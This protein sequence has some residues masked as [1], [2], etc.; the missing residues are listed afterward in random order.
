MSQRSVPS[1]PAHAKN[2]YLKP[3]T[4]KRPWLNLWGRFWWPFG[5]WT[6]PFCTQGRR[7]DRVSPCSSTLRLY[8]LRHRLATNPSS[9]TVVLETLKALVD[10]LVLWLVSRFRS[11]QHF[12]ASSFA[13]FGIEGHWQLI[14]LV[15]LWFRSPH[16]ELA[17]GTMRTS[18]PPHQ[19]RFSPGQISARTARR[20]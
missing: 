20:H 4:S 15:W 18:E 2:E 7:K 13:N 9:V 10:R 19:T 11:S 3:P 12:A 1:D 17:A 14:D 8:V 6:R 5:R 16:C